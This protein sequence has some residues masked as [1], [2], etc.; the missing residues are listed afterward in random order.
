MRRS[1]LL[2]GRQ[3]RLLS[4]GVH[5]VGPG[6][7]H[8]LGHKHNHHE[9]GSLSLLCLAVDVMVVFHTWKYFI[10]GKMFRYVDLHG[11]VKR[12]GTTRRV[13]HRHDDVLV[14][15]HGRSASSQGRTRGSVVRPPGLWHAWARTSSWVSHTAQLRPEEDK[16]RG[17]TAWLCHT[18]ACRSEAR[19]QEAIRY[20]V[21][22]SKAAPEKVCPGKRC[23]QSVP[24][25]SSMAWCRWSTCSWT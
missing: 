12:G 24:L 22:M 20:V 23:A 21:K 8:V 14:T 2:Q 10:W 1:S 9:T 6:Y 11:K 4:S 18:L 3:C 7:V 15:A 16:Q 19:A 13:W 5:G 25:L 17:L